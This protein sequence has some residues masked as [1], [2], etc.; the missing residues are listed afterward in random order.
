M[1]IA[2]MRAFI[3]I[4]RIKLEYAGIIDEIA[5][6]RQKVVNHSD[7]LNLIYDTIENLLDDKAD[8][9][10]WKERQRIGFLR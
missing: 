7:Q 10:I 3:E 9:K 4:K 8:T 1:N 2:I 5:E 6:I